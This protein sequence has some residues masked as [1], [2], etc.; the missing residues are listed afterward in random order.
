MRNQL[1]D[2]SIT[3][4]SAQ[5]RNLS[6]GLEGGIRQYRVSVSGR[7]G[8]PP[9]QVYAV[10]A[11]YKQHHPHI[12]PPEY[13]RRL[14]VLE[15]GVGAGTRTQIE[16]RVL[17]VTRVFEQVI[18]EPQ[19]GRILVETNQDGSAVTT[20]TVQPAGTYAA[21]QLT[22]TTDITARPGFAGFM[23]RLF[24][25]AMLPRIYQKE[26]ARLAAYLDNRAHFGLVEES[27]PWL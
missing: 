5:A 15:G 7:V 16:M 22:I 10:I 20:F 26:F 8:A 4:P 9:V 23:E 1:M 24:T 3:T 11:D 12:V 2:R 6:G 25:S 27:L 18:T 19:P 17:G 13:F 14:D 21:T